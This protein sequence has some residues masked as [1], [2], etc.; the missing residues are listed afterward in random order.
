ML[1]QEEKKIQVTACAMI[2]VAHDR[3]IKLSLD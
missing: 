1:C 2:L 3:P